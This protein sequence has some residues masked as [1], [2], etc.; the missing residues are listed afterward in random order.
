MSDSLVLCYH[1]VSEGWPCDISIRPAQLERQV[2]WFLDR[3]Y[4]PVSFTDAVTGSGGGRTI[5]VTF[6][7]AYRSIVEIAFPLLS[8]IGVEQATVFAPTA[9]VGTDRPIG[10]EGTDEW[11]GTA[12]ADEIQVMDWYE[13]GRLAAA[14][15]EIGSHTRTH[16]H[17]PRLGDAELADELVRSKQEL[18]R[19]LGLPCTSVAYPYGD[20]DGRVA[21]AAGAAGYAAGGGLLPNRLSERRPL[22]FPRISVGLGWSDDTLQRRARPGFRRLQSSRAWPPVARVVGLKRLLPMR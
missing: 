2:R 16:P 9:F 20:A 21:K 19:G 12:W 3:G 4:R 8:S 17:L 6:D 22:L 7:D 18:E 10:W 5:A 11:V 13:L 15:W 14:G 1:G